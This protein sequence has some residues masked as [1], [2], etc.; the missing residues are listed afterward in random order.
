VKWTEEIAGGEQETS[1]LKRGEAVKESLTGFVDKRKAS[2]SS[3]PC[4]P[5]D[6]GVWDW[7]E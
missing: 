2:D 3:M 1:D 4:G 5:H 7:E 6:I